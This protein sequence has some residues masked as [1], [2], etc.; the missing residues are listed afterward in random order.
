MLAF[1]LFRKYSQCVLSLA[2][3]AVIYK[4]PLQTIM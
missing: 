4:T 1:Y 3:K 2:G